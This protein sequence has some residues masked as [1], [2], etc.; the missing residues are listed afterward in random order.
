MTLPTTNEK[1]VPSFGQVL[2]IAPEPTGDGQVTQQKRW[3]LA[4]IQ[5]MSASAYQAEYSSNPDF[6]KAVEEFFVQP[7]STPVEK[8]EEKT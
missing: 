2:P 6:V 7:V 4:D 1:Y 5:R 8:T 3:R